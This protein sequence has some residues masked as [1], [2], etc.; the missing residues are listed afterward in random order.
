MVRSPWCRL[1]V[2]RV[3]IVLSKFHNSKNEKQGEFINNEEETVLYVSCHSIE[4]ALIFV[5]TAS[6]K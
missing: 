4:F 5:E 2:L 6:K 3:E 1:V